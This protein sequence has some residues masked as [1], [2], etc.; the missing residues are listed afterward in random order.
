M[1]LITLLTQRRK[2]KD[3]DPPPKPKPD[4]MLVPAPVIT[5]APKENTDVLILDILTHELRNVIST[6]LSKHGD[7]VKGI[8]PFDLEL[9]LNVHQ[10]DDDL[11]DA[12]AVIYL[13]NQYHWPDPLVRQL[14][15]VVQAL[16]RDLLIHRP[17]YCLG[18]E[19]ILRRG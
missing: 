4:D 16:R 1:E 13:S 15:D 3:D 8:T 11:W 19:G 6:Y 9:V 7:G 2:K 18:F 12:Q 10:N 5:I 17:D 14:E